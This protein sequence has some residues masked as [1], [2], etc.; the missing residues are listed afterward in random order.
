MGRCSGVRP[1]HG[2]RSF[3]RSLTVACHG[4]SFCRA[5]LL[6]GA[7]LPIAAS[8]PSGLSRPQQ[9]VLLQ[10]VAKLPC[11]PSYVGQD[12]GAVLDRVLVARG[13]KG[14]WATLT[15]RLRAQRVLQRGARVGMA[16]PD[17]FALG[18]RARGVLPGG[19]TVTLN[20]EAPTLGDVPDVAPL[21]AL[22]RG[23]KAAARPRLRAA[24]RRAA[25][26]SA[27]AFAELAARQ[28]CL[29]ARGCY[30]DVEQMLS[31][32]LCTR[33][34]AV[35]PLS[36][37]VGVVACK[38]VGSSAKVGGDGGSGEVTA[39]SALTAAPGARAVAAAA[40]DFDTTLLRAKAAR[41]KDDDARARVQARA[42]ALL[43]LPGAVGDA[44]VPVAP[45]AGEKTR[46]PR[47]PYSV[48]VPPSGLTAGATLCA[49]A[50][51][52]LADA[53][54]PLPL[55][56]RCEGDAP[57]PPL[58]VRGLASLRARA[59]FGAFE[60]L[61]GD[62]SSLQARL[63]VG[64]RPVPTSDAQKGAV[65]ATL[66]LSAAQQLIGP[67]RARADACFALDGRTGA[68]AGK[69]TGG[70]LLQDRVL[71]SALALDCAVVPGGAARAVLWW[72]PTRQEGMFEVRLLEL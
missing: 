59:H 66:S 47:R 53:M 52:P 58:G 41:D 50:S 68:G 28:R 1:I 31:A 54:I 40:W 5:Q 60:R 44:R 34:G 45:A 51:V 65:S 15:G 63:D 9:L 71:D 8:R 24:V 48:L 6:P 49:V 72:S 56:W 69:R 25:G 37:S 12:G 26:R 18:A 19:A 70:P 2:N 27:D 32:G 33:K 16:D 13:R 21:K 17:S 43:A 62:W 4:S 11:L 22:R 42:S 29:D 10:G 46:T 38:G 23:S 64:S 57:Q 7:P 39:L 20:A 30:V 36:A 14:W 3:G 61:F 55:H 67:L 35:G